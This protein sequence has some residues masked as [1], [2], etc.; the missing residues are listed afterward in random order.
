MKKRR[1][2]FNINSVF[3]VLNAFLFTLLI[4]AS[5]N[6]LYGIAKASNPISVAEMASKIKADCEHGKSISLSLKLNCYEGTFRNVTLAKG[7]EYA[8]DILFALQKI[9]SF[10][11]SCH[12]IA[13]QIGQAAFIKNPSDW[14][15]QVRAINQACAYGAMHGL[16]EEYFE[17]LPKEKSFGEGLS[18]ICESNPHDM[19]FHIV[20]HLLLVETADKI[21]N[22]IDL[23]SV[24]QDKRQRHF[25]LT[26]VYMEHMIVP[27]LSAHGFYNES[28][29]KYWF[30]YIDDF[31]NLCR[32][33]NGENAVACWNMLGHAAVN[34]FHNNPRIIFDFCNRAQ[35]KDAARMCKLYAVGLIAQFERLRLDSLKYMCTLERNKDPSFENECYLT[36]AGAM[37]AAVPHRK[38]DVFMFCSSLDG[39]FR[40]TCFSH[41]G[42]TFRTNG[43]ETEDILKLCRNL[44]N[45]F[46]DQ[47]IK[48]V[49]N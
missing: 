46:Q 41:M 23:C 14:K 43:M 16:M 6:K 11:L 47:C 18:E 27:G 33:Y 17:N 20:G 37:N 31:E 12:T 22:A 29:R 15:T 49:N 26:G 10:T 5:L 8:F 25:C 24:F 1:F 30:N 34:K 3:I 21:D 19:C 38:A 36:L 13:H 45:E 35:L 4:Y 28:R 48:N 42:E 44:P 2:I 32:S 39:N 9:D 7:P 40:G